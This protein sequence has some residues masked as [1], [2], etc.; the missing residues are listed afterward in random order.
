MFRTVALGQRPTTVYFDDF[1]VFES[2]RQPIVS[3][4][5]DDGWISQFTTAMPKMDEYGFKGTAY[6]IPS[7]IGADGFFTQAQIDVIA[8]NGW[9]ISATGRRT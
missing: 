4:V 1:S 6:I 5:F 7:G 3:L 9:D 8:D 2:A